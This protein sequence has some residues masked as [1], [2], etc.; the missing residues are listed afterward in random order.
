MDAGSSWIQNTPVC[1]MLA[2]MLFEKT[3]IWWLWKHETN[4]NVVFLKE[5]TII[6]FEKIS[7][8]VTL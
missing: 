6:L 1:E 2:R 7:N 8:I 4:R 3:D 5:N